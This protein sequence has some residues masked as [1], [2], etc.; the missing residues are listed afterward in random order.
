MSDHPG[1]QLSPTAQESGGILGLGKTSRQRSAE[2]LAGMRAELMQKP[3]YVAMARPVGRVLGA[4]LVRLS[5]RDQ[6]RLNAVIARTEAFR[7][8]VIQAL[9]G[10]AEA[11]CV[12]LA[13][14]FVPRAWQ[15]A[16]EFPHLRVTEVDWPE[17]IA[18]KQRRFAQA[19]LAL[20][21]NLIM[22][23]TNLGVKPLAEVLEGERA[24]VIAAEGLLPYSS[25]SI[26]QRILTGA[27]HS[28]KPNGVFI[29][30]VITR[31]NYRAMT[32]SKIRHAIDLFRRNVGEPLGI[33]DD[34]D[35]VNRFFISAG[36][37]EVEVHQIPDLIARLPHV[38]KPV[39]IITSIV[40]AR[41]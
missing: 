17:V 9:E 6:P 23:S 22:R 41:S 4:L 20:P 38:P 35:H 14:G 29:G 32:Q 12:E 2:I 16:S 28:L 37:S 26:I 3:E 10:R 1:E 21:P 34:Y 7:H 5:R 15:L 36:Y 25:P 27:Y 18:E 30:D 24:D 31:E 33:M 11:H 40:V 39:A 19:N 13:S 8:L